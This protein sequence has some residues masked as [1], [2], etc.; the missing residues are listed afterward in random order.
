MAQPFGR[1][2]FVGASGYLGK[3]TLAALA[4]SR[5]HRITVISRTVSS[6]NF[7]GYDDVVVRRGSYEDEA[8]MHSALRDQDVLIIMLNFLAM[9]E[10]DRLLLAASKA[11]VRFVI[12]SDYMMDSSNPDMCNAVPLTQNSRETQLRVQALGMKSIAVVCNLWL[13]FVGTS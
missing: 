4:A 1:I 7:P 3:Q 8:F 2:A 6:A 10:Q 5:K 12:P 11:G 13:D 9:S